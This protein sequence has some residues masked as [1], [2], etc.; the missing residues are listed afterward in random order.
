MTSVKGN[1]MA[2]DDIASGKSE[3]FAGEVQRRDFL[4]SP[5]FLCHL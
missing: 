5:L 4:G 1:D 2:D 3:G